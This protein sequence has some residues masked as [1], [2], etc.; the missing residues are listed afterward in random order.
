M[1]SHSCRRQQ[2]LKF[3]ARSPAP[4]IDPD[5]DGFALDSPMYRGL[6]NNR[7]VLR[8]NEP[9][10]LPGDV[11]AARPIL[12]TDGDASISRVQFTPNRIDFGVTTKGA[13]ARVFMNQ[14]YIAGWRST[15]GPVE[16]DQVT[17]MPYVTIPATAAGTYSFT[18]A[19]KGLV[20]GLMASMMGLALAAATWRRRL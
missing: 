2:T 18:F 6:M 9:L 19:P 17:Q 15:A 7:G 4:A 3:G 10:H 13:P 8:C 20:A 5:T 11:N 14:R 1:S 16:I 12:F